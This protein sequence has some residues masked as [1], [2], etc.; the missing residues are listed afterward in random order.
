LSNNQ[1][2]G[3]P[4]EV[5][6]LSNLENLN[7]SNNQLTGLPYEL[8]N[9]GNLKLLNISGNDYSQ[10]DLNIILKDLPSSTEIIK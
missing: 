8:G 7:L 4:A 6:Q 2:T 5:G 1:L 3:V 10:Q 9:L